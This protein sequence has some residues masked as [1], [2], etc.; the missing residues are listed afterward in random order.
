L[1]LPARQD[2]PQAQHLAL[3]YRFLALISPNPLCENSRSLFHQ[4]ATTE[5]IPISPSLKQG[6][7]SFSSTSILFISRAVL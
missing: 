7:I 2:K 3:A 4:K 5:T 1:Q 6:F